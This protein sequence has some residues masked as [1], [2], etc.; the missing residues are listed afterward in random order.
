MEELA[1]RLVLGARKE[2]VV[3]SQALSNGMQMLAYPLPEGAVVALGY[4]REQAHLVQT[5]TVL[6]RR[7]RDMARFGPW[8]PSMLADG[9]W[10]LVRR[11]EDGRSSGLTERDMQAALELLS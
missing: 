5:E 6:R 2:Q 10:Y 1:R 7:S 4:P 9:G 11:L 8:L 3:V